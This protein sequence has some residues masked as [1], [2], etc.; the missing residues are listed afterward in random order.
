MCA[1]RSGRSNVLAGT[2]SAAI[3]VDHNVGVFWARSSGGVD[4]AAAQHE[5]VTVD[6]CKSM[7]G[8]MGVRGR[9]KEGGW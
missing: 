9:G 2:A 4:V 5:M 7:D 1:L 3:V 8:W 6:G